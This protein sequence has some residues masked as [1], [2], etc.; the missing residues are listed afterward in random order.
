MEEKAENLAAHL[1]NEANLALWHICD[2]DLADLV[3]H[4]HLAVLVARHEHVVLE[5]LHVLGVKPARIVARQERGA[6]TSR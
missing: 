4:N 1:V 6:V 5:R 2:M 3:E